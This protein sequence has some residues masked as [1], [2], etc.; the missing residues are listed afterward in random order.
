MGRF[1]ICTHPQI[2]LGI[3]NQEKRGV[4]GHVVLIGD[5]RKVYRV[6][7]RKPEGKKSLDTP[8]CR[9]EDGT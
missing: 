6:L 8:G 2:S 4:V 9:W 1:I 7:V 5:G 3:S